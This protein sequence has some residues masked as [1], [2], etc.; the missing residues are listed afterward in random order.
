LPFAIVHLR[1]SPQLLLIPRPKR[2]DSGQQYSTHSTFKAH[3]TLVTPKAHFG[4]S[5]AIPDMAL[6]EQK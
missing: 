3:L 5:E 4:S 1:V 6:D 2:P